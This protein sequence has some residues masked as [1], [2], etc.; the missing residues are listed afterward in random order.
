MSNINTSNIF[1]N[2]KNNKILKGA[3][4]LMMLSFFYNLPVMGYSIT[5]ENEL[6]I[7]DFAGAYIVWFYFN[8]KIYV[9]DYINRI[10]F[11]RYFHQ[12]IVWT[13]I[14]ML[15][16]LSFSLVCDRILW[17]F[18]SVLYLFH[19]WLFY[20][21]AV[22]LSILITDLRFLKKI[23]SFILL[24]A[25]IAFV[26]VILQ[27]LNIIPFLWSDRYFLSYH[28]FLSGTFGP[29]KIVVGISAIIVFVFSL[30]LIND[31]R[32]SIN[33]I[34][35]VATIVTTLLVIGLSGSR[36]TYLGMLVFTIY[37]ALRNTFKFL[38]SIIFLSFIFI[39]VSSYD[40]TI[41]NKINETFEKR[42]EN[43][44]KDPKTLKEGNVNELY[45]DLGAG[46]KNL[47]LKYVDYLLENPYIIP[48]GIGFNNRLIIGFSAHNIYLSLINEVGLVGFFFYFRWLFSIL[49]LRLK[50]F[51]QLEYALKGM[52]L[53]MIVTLFFGEHLYVYRPIFGLFGLFFSIVVLLSS[54]VFCYIAKKVYEE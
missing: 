15:F 51:T 14:T 47:S 1:G 26:I 29:N 21:T 4:Y 18:Q 28:G 46:R 3:I 19:F 35:L 11:F 30:G 42:I 38:I 2:V 20:L 17:F 12:F 24:V 49:L 23:V 33:K 52:V 37:Y 40:S 36:T 5:G 54:P 32:V 31:K 7:Y 25:I 48:F 22:F 45:E 39:C 53:A 27:N 50:P 43:K 41:L 10:F 9:R 16:T 44:I 13:S 34:L 6:R 8:N